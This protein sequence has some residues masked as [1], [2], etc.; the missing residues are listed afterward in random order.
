MCGGH[1]VDITADQFGQAP[2]LIS[3]ASDQRYRPGCN[4]STTLRL[5]ASGMSAVEKLKGLWRDRS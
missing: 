2:V 3:G 1:I 4:E 5:T